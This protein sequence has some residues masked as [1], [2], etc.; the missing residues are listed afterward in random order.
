MTN[1]ERI[2]AILD[3][4][5]QEQDRQG[6]QLGEVCQLSQRTAVLLETEYHDKLQLLF[7]G[8]DL[9]KQRLDALVPKKDIEHLETEVNLLRSIVISMGKR[10]EALEKAQ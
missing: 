1:E 7:D 4:V 2:L 3:K 6:K 9:I 10:L 8:H 5:S